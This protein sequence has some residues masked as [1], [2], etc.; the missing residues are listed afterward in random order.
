M[1]NLMTLIPFVL[2][3]FI[4]ASTGIMFPPGGWYEQIAKPSWQPP[5]WLFA[6]VWTTLYVMIAIAGWLAWSAAGFSAALAVYALQLALNAA[7]TPIFFGLHRP[8]LAFVEMIV[9]WLCIAATILLFAPI[10]L[11][12]AALLVPYLGWVSFAAFLNF[13]IWRLNGDRPAVAG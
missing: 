3:C 2:G 11:V 10:N 12:A 5:K 8:G 7:W 13:T 9:L 1:P 4:A 6:P